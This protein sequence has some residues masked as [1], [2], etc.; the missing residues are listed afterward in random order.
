M[1]SGLILAFQF[2]TRIPVPIAIDFNDKN[3]SRA[4][5]FFSVVGIIMALIYSNVYKHLSNLDKEI[6]AFFILI[7]MVILTGG[8]HLD[9]L[10]DVADGFFSGRGKEET[11]KI[12][13]DSRTGAFGT[14]AIVLLLLTK[15]I[16]LQKIEYQNLFFAVVNSRMG[17]YI[18]ILFG[19]APSNGLG[20]TFQR[21]APKKLIILEI[22]IY[23]VILIYLGLA[24]LYT[25]LFSIL[26]AFLLLLYSNKKIAGV[27]GDVN[28]AYIEL[29]EALNFILYWG[30]S[31]GDI[32]N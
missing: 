30:L 23:M 6:S 1:I 9:G 25:F 4:I 20:D 16:F 24:Y 13:K 11:L 29:S 8:L 27:N 28:G 32:L 22:I 19:R 5:G 7:L 3:I 10:S 26:L 17:V 15:F 14:I 31:Y 18:L 2:L 21:L 12:M